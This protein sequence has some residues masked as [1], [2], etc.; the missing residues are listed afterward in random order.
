MSLQPYFK[1]ANEAAALW[2]MAECSTRPELPCQTL[3]LP[4]EWLSLVQVAC[5]HLP[6]RS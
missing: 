1:L 6:T 5:G 2:M 4:T 3:E